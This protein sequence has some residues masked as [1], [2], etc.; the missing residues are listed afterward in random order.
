[1]RERVRGQLAE[2][3]SRGDWAAGL[4]LLRDR[5]EARAAQLLPNDWY[6]LS[7]SLEVAL[8]RQTG[9]EESP[10]APPRTPPLG[11][12]DLRCFFVSEDR[13]ALYHTIDA[14]CLDMLG[15]GLLEEVT[16]LLANGRLPADFVGS[17]SIGYRQTIKVCWW[18]LSHRPCY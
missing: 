13:E 4:Q 3:E 15:A 17:K 2:L 16:Q 14:R 18:F 8:A 6:R 10:D 9:A 5:D 1:M 12:C 7:R 11:D